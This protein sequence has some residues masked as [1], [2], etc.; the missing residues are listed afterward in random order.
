MAALMAA[1]AQVACEPAR[2]ASTEAPAVP[3]GSE[4]SEVPEP[5]ASPEVTTREAYADHLNFVGRPE[6]VAFLPAD[7]DIPSFVVGASG[8][9][10][11]SVPVW[12]FPII[13]D[14]LAEGEPTSLIVRNFSEPELFVA[15]E[16]ASWTWVASVYLPG[17]EKGDISFVVSEGQIELERSTIPAEDAVPVQDDYGVAVGWL[18]ERRVSF[19]PEY[20]DR[21][22][23]LTFISPEMESLGADVDIG[24]DAGNY[25]CERLPSSVFD[26]PIMPLDAVPGRKYSLF[27]DAQPKD[28]IVLYR[29][30]PG[31]PTW[32]PLAAWDASKA[33]WATLYLQVE[34]GVMKGS[35]RFVAFSEAKAGIEVREAQAVDFRY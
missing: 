7:G 14:D 19:S 25:L 1:L 3:A 31:T 28:R 10:L 34:V 5:S 30:I 9:A 18:F 29:P 23:R 33:D 11:P 27:M 32:M 4:A 35:Y 8:K 6:L 16:G 12:T 22:M 13:E 26:R 24:P 2:T 21:N 15:R 20:R 17:A